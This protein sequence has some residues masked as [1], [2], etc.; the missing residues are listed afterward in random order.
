MIEGLRLTLVLVLCKGGY[1]G[2][3]VEEQYRDIVR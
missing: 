3:Y 1:T 2:D